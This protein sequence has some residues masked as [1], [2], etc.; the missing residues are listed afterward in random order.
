MN[1]TD[2]DG[3]G[4]SAR[5]HYFGKGRPSND[6]RPDYHMTNDELFACYKKSGELGDRFGRQASVQRFRQGC[7]LYI[8]HERIGRGPHHGWI[9]LLAEKGIRR[10]TA[11]RVE[12][13]YSGA[14]KRWGNN[15]EDE[16]AQRDL[17]DLYVIFGILPKKKRKR[18][19]EGGVTRGSDAGQE[20]AQKSIAES[21]QREDEETDQGEN[22][23]EELGVDVG[24]RDNRARTTVVG[25]QERQVGKKEQ[26]ATKRKPYKR[27]LS[28]GLQITVDLVE[29]SVFRMHLDDAGNDD[30][31]LV[32][33]R[34]QIETLYSQL[35]SAIQKDDACVPAEIPTERQA[36]LPEVAEN[37]R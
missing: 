33:H 15:A 19:V 20:T 11:N 36:A 7:A 30:I 17:T 10:A 23:G 9:P 14:Y 3:A 21:H 27:A 13:L 4:V 6:D 26:Q 16:V 2:V 22:K 32:L 1:H 18:A 34:P 8:L 29:P 31:E 28:S 12:R 24:L 25:S 5:S 37:V 35:R